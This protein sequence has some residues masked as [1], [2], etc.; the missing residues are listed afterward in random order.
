MTI[1]NNRGFKLGPKHSILLKI[2][3]KKII[4][5][6]KRLN[7]LEEMDQNLFIDGLNKANF[8]KFNLNLN[9]LK[10]LIHFSKSIFPESIFKLEYGELSTI[11]IGKSYQG[12]YFLEDILPIMHFLYQFKDKKRFIKAIRINLNN[13]KQ[14]SN[15]IFELQCLNQFNKNGFNFVYEP[16]ITIKNKI[17]KPDFKLFS[18]D[19]IVYCECKSLSFNLNLYSIKFYEKASKLLSSFRK[20]LK[21]NLISYNLRLEINFTKSPLEKDI[22]TVIDN[23]NNMDEINEQDLVSLDSIQYLIIPR[24]NQ[25]YFSKKSGILSEVLATQDEKYFNFEKA[26]DQDIV[27]FSN[28]LTIKQRR[29][30]SKLLTDAKKKLPNDFP[31]I[32]ILNDV[33]PIP[34]KQILENRMK[35]DSYS[36]IIAI[37]LNPFDNFFSCYKTNAKKLLANLFYNFVSKNLFRH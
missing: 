18:E 5:F 12:F 28:D 13:L 9:E 10:K 17:K 36:N 26:S 16:E 35:D 14:F 33:K 31:G 22:M 7:L 11:K 27:I 23:I 8:N 25:F 1:N 19:K 37:V 6:S 20:D 3:E 32:I 15:T 34:L 21:E 24:E 2:S 4:I 30:C 29:A